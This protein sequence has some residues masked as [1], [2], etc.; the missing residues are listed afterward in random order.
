[1][2]PPEGTQPEL[3][4]AIEGQPDTAPLGRRQGINLRPL[5]KWVGSKHRFA[6]DIIGLF[7]P[8]FGRYFEPFLG[9][10]AVLGH[11]GYG[12]AEASDV[13][14][15]LIEIWQE[16]V[17]RPDS[18]QRWYRKRWTHALRTGW[19][20][21][22]EEIKAD[23]NRSPNGPDLLYLC[24]ACYA[25]IVRFRKADGY[26]ST[27]CGIHRPIDPDTFA[28]RVQD[29]SYRTAGT[30]FRCEDFS[31]AMSRAGRNDLIYCDPPYRHTQPILYGAQGFSLESL[32]EMIAEC[33]RRGTFV[34]L[35]IDG[36]K[37]SGTVECDLPIP[38]GLF[39]REV[40][41]SCGRSMIRRFQMGGKTLEGEVVSDRLLLTF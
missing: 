10:G 5:L 27:P 19:R 14:E 40:I 23:Y 31:Q 30:T 3:F 7:P 33:K 38:T 39:H 12:R 35:S 29:W 36:S 37:R 8:H 28:A 1:M 2:P 32:M 15:P 24:R 17:R 4:P 6:R 34:A 20:E 22:Y 25:G 9:S 13:F 11:L 21:A 41:V 18:L 16:L 26:M